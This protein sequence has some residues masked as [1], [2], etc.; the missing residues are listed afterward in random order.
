MDVCVSG[1]YRL[2]VGSEFMGIAHAC[3][4][5]MFAPSNEREDETR[6]PSASDF[7]HKS[8]Q[9]TQGV[10]EPV[11][12]AHPTPHTHTFPN[13]HSC[14]YDINA[15]SI[16]RPAINVPKGSTNQCGASVRSCTPERKADSSPTKM[17]PWF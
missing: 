17:W 7:D 10:D 12:R 14:I 5:I 8:S 4:A 9:H 1:V 13:T 3:G 11:R 15:H 2:Y 6:N 16:D